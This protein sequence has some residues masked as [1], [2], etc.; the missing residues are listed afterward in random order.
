MHLFNT[1]KPAHN[2]RHI[3]HQAQQN[4]SKPSDP[5]ALE[6]SELEAQQRAYEAEHGG[7]LASG[8]TGS[9]QQS[10]SLIE[11]LQPRISELKQLIGAPAKLASIEAELQNIARRDGGIRTEIS[12][13]ENRITELRTKEVDLADKLASHLAA[14]ADAAIDGD[15]VEA[16]SWLSGASFEREAIER[17]I[18]SLIRQQQQLAAE[19]ASTPQRVT[20]LKRDHIATRHIALQAEATRAIAGI[21]DTLL[22]ANVARKRANPYSDANIL[23][24]VFTNAEVEAEMAAQ[25]QALNSLA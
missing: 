6:L 4:M 21:R 14:A 1:G 13:L 18:N 19:L 5:I 25:A 24:I 9:A 10:K 15:A 23:E 16:P 2:L 3:I 22:K 8:D 7:F 17:A 20:D 11:R 12:R